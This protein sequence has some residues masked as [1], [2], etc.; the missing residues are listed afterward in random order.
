[1]YKISQIEETLKGRFKN[2]PQKSSLVN[3]LDS[4]D[5]YKNMN[6]LQIDNYYKDII[7]NEKFQMEQTVNQKALF[8][9]NNVKFTSIAVDVVKNRNNHVLFL[10]LN[11]G[12]V[13]KIMNQIQSKNGQNFNQPIILGEYQMFANNLPINSIILFES[14]KLIAITNSEIKSI[15]LEIQCKKYKTCRQCVYAQDPNCA[16]STSKSKCVL[17]IEESESLK[18]DIQN[19]DGAKICAASNTDTDIFYSINTPVFD[20]SENLQKIEQLNASSSNNS[21]IIFI[22]IL[23]TAILT[24]IFSVCLTWVYIKKRYE[25]HPKDELIGTIKGT[26]YVRR[27]WQSLKNNPYVISVLN[28]LTQNQNSAGNLSR[29]LG[30]SEH[31]HDHNLLKQPK[32]LNCYETPHVMCNT[33]KSNLKPVTVNTST[34]TS[35]STRPNSSSEDSSPTTTS[36]LT[37]SSNN[38]SPNNLG[39]KCSRAS[40][41]CDDDN[42]IDEEDNGL[43]TP[44]SSKYSNI[45][46]SHQRLSSSDDSFQPVIIRSSQSSSSGNRNLNNTN[47]T[48]NNNNKYFMIS[49][50][51]S[52]SKNPRS[53]ELDL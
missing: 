14:K 5:S 37:A 22:I 16:W 4:C 42:D 43:L 30:K 28:Q 52:D 19:G 41:E 33:N 39:S 15:S 7:K 17:A 29:D 3:P 50:D 48:S 25:T 11:D 34:S 49:K 20:D 6:T 32:I 8:A 10:G 18:Q 24:S 21:S 38:N 31:F 1:M 45:I 12:R 53:R 23:F 46:I 26:D 47:N 13:L 9:L 36:S 2:N 44:V 35:S 51:N 40:C 27:M